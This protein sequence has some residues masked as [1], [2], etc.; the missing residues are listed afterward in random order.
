[1]SSFSVW[2]PQQ[3]TSRLRSSGVSHPS[4]KG[5]TQAFQPFPVPHFLFLFFGIL[6][7]DF[8][9][10]SF[11]R[12]LSRMITITKAPFDFIKQI[13][14][15][16][17][18]PRFSPAV[19]SLNLGFGSKPRKEGGFFGLVWTADDTGGMELLKKLS[20]GCLNNGL[21]KGQKVEVENVNGG[22]DIFDAASAEA[23]VQP[24][25]LVIMVNGLVG[26]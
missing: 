22:E 17:L 6:F 24:Q 5:P 10:F 25:H 13:P 14:R 12:T 1:M 18:I 4:S 3:S 19:V 20:R 2:K 8:F 26:R 16:V 7:L 9:F 23:K 15:T 21:E 11:L